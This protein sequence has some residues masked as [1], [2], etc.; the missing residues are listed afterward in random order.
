LTHSGQLVN[1]DAT[2]ARALCSGRWL[3]RSCGS[4]LSDVLQNVL[5]LG[6]TWKLVL[7]IVF[8]LL[9]C[10]LRRGIVGA[11]VDLYRLATRRHRKPTEPVESTVEAIASPRVSNTTIADR[12]AA[13]RTGGPIPRATGLSKRYGGLLANSD[14]DFVVNQ[15]EMRRHYRAEWGRQEHLLQNADLRDRADVG[16]DRL[17]W[18]GYHGNERHRCVSTGDSPKRLSDQSAI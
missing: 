2:A 10:F 4:N 14:I 17:R 5:H 6:S 13:G 8:V 11:I 3:G 15:G 16:Q 12:R 9:V 1:A 18:P 7:G